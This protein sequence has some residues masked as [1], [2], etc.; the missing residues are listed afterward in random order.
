[1]AGACSCE[2]CCLEKARAFACE[3]GGATVL[4]R[5]TTREPS[6]T[7]PV[8]PGAAPALAKAGIGGYAHIFDD[9][10]RA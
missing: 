1:M 3:V 4:P 8:A 2:S 7:P 5:Q 6:S 10:C 9:I